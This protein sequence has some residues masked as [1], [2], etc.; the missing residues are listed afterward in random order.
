MPLNYKVTKASAS[1]MPE[2]LLLVEDTQKLHPEIIEIAEQLAADK[3]LDSA[4]NCRELF[5][6]YGIAPIIDK[7]SDWKDKDPTRALDPDRADNIVYD[8]KG[9]IS[10][11]CPETGE[12][13]AMSPWGFEQDR[14]TLKYRCPAAADDFDC[15]GRAQCHNAQTEHGRIVRLNI[16]ADRRMFTPI[17]RDSDAWARAYDRRTASERVN[18]RIDNLLGFERHTIRGQKKMETRIGI[19]LVVLLAMALGRIKAGQREQLRSLVGPVKRAA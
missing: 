9:F 6:R 8:V 19:A 17:P 11:V 16:N 13:R 15:K 18:S 7:R 12:Q 2:L 14:N 3:G 10:C 1:E 4:E 5:E